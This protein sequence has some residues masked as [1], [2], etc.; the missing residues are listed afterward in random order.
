MKNKIYV[1][2]GLPCTGKST[3]IKNLK[4][5][6]KFYD[7]GKVRHKNVFKLQN[8]DD[9]LVDRICS[10]TEFISMSNLEKVVIDRFTP[11]QYVFG[12]LIRNYPIEEIL[13]IEDYLL[14]LVDMEVILFMDNVQNIQERIINRDGKVRYDNAFMQSLVYKF[15]EWKEKTKLKNH[16]IHVSHYEWDE[17]YSII[18]NIIK[19]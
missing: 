1:L 9:I 18:E 13:K 12:N 6:N 3:V 4:I 2:D 8:V 16:I 14:T 7:N 19:G 17:V 15:T 11:S 10:I 5:D